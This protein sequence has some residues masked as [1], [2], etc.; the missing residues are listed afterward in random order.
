[1]ITF[2]IR[3]SART[4]DNSCFVVIVF[5]VN[6]ASSV[7]K[8]LKKSTTEDSSGAFNLHLNV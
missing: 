3:H 1:M 8:A 6:V 7:C 2:H 4:N 5:L